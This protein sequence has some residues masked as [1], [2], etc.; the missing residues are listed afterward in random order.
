VTAQDAL[1][2]F[3]PDFGVDDAGQSFIVAALLFAELPWLSTHKPSVFST[4][5]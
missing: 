3:V 2:G 5:N 1:P 4:T